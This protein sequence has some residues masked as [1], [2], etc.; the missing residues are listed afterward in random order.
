[1]F[2][3]T[4]WSAPDVV[5]YSIPDR[6]ENLSPIANAGDDQTVDDSADCTGSSYTEYSCED[7]DP[8]VLELDGSGSYDPNGDDI[9]YYWSEASGELAISMPY[10]AF[11]EVTTPEMAADLST[12]NTTVWTVTLDVADCAIS[13]SDTITITYECTGER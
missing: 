13:S 10:S 1:M 3:G 7:C 4:L 9:T 6:S 11:T 5:T 2:D 12:T 8:E